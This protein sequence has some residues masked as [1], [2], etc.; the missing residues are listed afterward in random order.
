MQE[1]HREKILEKIE[2]DAEKAR[3]IK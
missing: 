2:R 3:A 1:Y